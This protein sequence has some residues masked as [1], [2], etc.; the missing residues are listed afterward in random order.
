M[1]LAWGHFV[2]VAGRL[3]PDALVPWEGAA[4]TPEQQNQP[5]YVRVVVP[6]DTAPGLYTGSLAV[7]SQGETS[8]VPISVRVF[9]FRSARRGRRAGGR[10]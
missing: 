4:R 2:R 6:R 9:G 10:C 7:S 1:S 5:V 3:T 8:T